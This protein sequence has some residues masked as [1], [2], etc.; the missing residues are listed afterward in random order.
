MEDVQPLGFVLAEH[1][2][3]DRIDEGFNGAIA[4]AKNHAAP[5]E[6]VEGAFLTR[7][8]GITSH[9]VDGTVSHEGHGG[10]DEVAQEREQHR[11]FIA[12]A[13]D[14]KAPQNDG[15]GEGPDA[16]PLQRPDGALVDV[17]VDTQTHIAEIHA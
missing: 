17:E 13:V 12:D 4:E 6:E 7:H 8:Q 14:D 9:P 1:G 16:R 11:D 10:I 15:D 3:D 2:G 5:V